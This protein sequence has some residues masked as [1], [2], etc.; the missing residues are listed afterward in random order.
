MTLEDMQKTAELTVNMTVGGFKAEDLF[1]L[2][3]TLHDVQDAGRIPWV[4]IVPT[5]AFNTLFDDGH[6]SANVAKFGEIQAR[7]TKA[8]L[9]EYLAYKVLEER[10]GKKDKE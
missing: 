8:M 5:D 1:E 6:F 2:G 4:T 9:D 7:H 10:K 3:K